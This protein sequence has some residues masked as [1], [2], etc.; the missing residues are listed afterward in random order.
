MRTEKS[1]PLVAE[2]G[3][4]LH[5]LRALPKSA[6]GKAV[7]YAV[8]LW[9]GLTLFL[10]NSRIPL[11]NNAAERIVRGPVI[12][13]KNYYGARSERGCQVAAIFYSLL[14]S[15]KLCGLEPKSYLRIA[16]QDALA[17]RLVRLPH[18]LKAASR[19]ENSP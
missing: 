7:Q 3:E 14:E 8:N 17:G 2:L 19:A 6:L 9:A 13:R 12:G 4:W 10:K 15:A 1:A 11:S 5:T 16:I 18:E